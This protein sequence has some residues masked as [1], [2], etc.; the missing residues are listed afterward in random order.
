MNELSDS[1][2]NDSAETLNS[3]IAMINCFE[4]INQRSK[5]KLKIVVKEKKRADI[6]DMIARYI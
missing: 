3:L 5:L 4:I 2:F 1:G 6:I